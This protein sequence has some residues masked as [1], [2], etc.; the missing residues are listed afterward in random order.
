MDQFGHTSC[1]YRHISQVDQVYKCI[2]QSSQRQKSHFPLHQL[3]KMLDVLLDNQLRA[4]HFCFERFKLERLRPGRCG[5]ETPIRG[6]NLGPEMGL[7]LDQIGRI[8]SLNPNLRPILTSEL[9]LSPS[10]QQIDSLL[11]VIKNL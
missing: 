3:S 1:R 2:Y 7:A 9:Q 4:L 8:E 6:L 5:S 10:L 11:Y